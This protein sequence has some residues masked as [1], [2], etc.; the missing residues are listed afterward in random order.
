MIQ[1]ILFDLDN[2]LYSAK[3]GLEDNVWKRVLEF[4]ADYLNISVDKTIEER[5]K[6]MQQYGTTIE[7]LINEK[8]FTNLD[9]F[10]SAVYPENEADLLPENFEL[11]YFLESISIPKAI[12]TNSVREHTDRILNKLNVSDLFTHIFDIRFNN[13]CGKP[14]PK[15]FYE[16]LKVL[17][18]KPET[19]L[20]I[21]D[22][23]NYVEGFR[24]ISGKG[25]LFD[26]L[27]SYPDYPY[28]KI[29]TLS[30]LTAF[31]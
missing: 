17:N 18:T 5:K 15:A 4:T 11:R 24:S 28:E 7:W 8:G 22:Y 27:N 29:K 13:F 31:L 25:L 16:S 21:D 1:Y 2:T 6:S 9:A 30:E 14:K 10:Y 23:P 3:Y 12:L 26:E 19:T 20:F